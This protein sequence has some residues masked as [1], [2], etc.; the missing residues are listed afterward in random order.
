M[1]PARNVEDNIAELLTIIGAQI[2]GTS[3]EVIVVDDASDDGTVAAAQEWARRNPDVALTVLCA[4]R[5][6]WVNKSRN[7]G[8]AAS[9][10]RFMV[11]IDGDD[12]AAHD[13]FPN[14]MSSVREGD[15]GTV[16]TGFVDHLDGR[17]PFGRGRIFGLPTISGGNC[18]MSRELAIRLGGFDQRIRRGGT[19]DEFA[20]RAVQHHGV[21]VTERPDA[22]IRYK[23]SGVGAPLRRR[24][25]REFQRTAGE[26]YICRRFAKDQLPVGVARLPE[27]RCLASAMRS[28]ARALTWPGRVSR[29]SHVVYGC[30]RLSAAFWHFRFRL[31]LPESELL[32]DNIL[33]DYHAW[34][35]TRP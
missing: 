33:E 31:H 18:A 9:R 30:G 3:T 4:S 13:W 34:T 2:S 24:L 25:I 23:Y 19:E 29:K 12:L 32:A 27:I 35:A 21:S 28:F 22:V 8:I 11:F 17:A 15:A 5:R 20:L 14:L 16:V 10:G 26:A 6:G 7:A 1:I